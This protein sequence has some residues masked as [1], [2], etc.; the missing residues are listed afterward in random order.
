MFFFNCTFHVT[1]PFPS[2][3]DSCRTQQWLLPLTVRCSCLHLPKE[4]NMMSEL[5][6][7]TLHGASGLH[8]RVRASEQGREAGGWGW[9]LDCRCW[10]KCVSNNNL[11]LR[12]ER[13][14]WRCH[15][16]V[17]SSL[18]LS[19]QQSEVVLS[20]RHQIEHGGVK[21]FKVSLRKTLPQRGGPLQKTE[22][23]LL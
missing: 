1:R 18:P 20:R 14:P 16:A 6:P 7:P 13:L 23:M 9:V 8:R 22:G 19:W 15:S 11:H 4:G 12:L 5:F 17:Q 21:F 2:S 3:A 10:V